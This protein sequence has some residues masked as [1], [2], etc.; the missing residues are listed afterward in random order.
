[1]AKKDFD[2]MVTKPY[3]T[4][5]EVPVG[6]DTLDKA[7]KDNLE[8]LPDLQKYIR[9]L[10]DSEKTKLKESIETHGC[11]DSIKIWN[12]EGSKY[13]II[14][15]HNR[16]DI[17]KEIGVDFNYEILDFDSIEDV[18]EYMISY[19]MGRR[20]LTKQEVSYYRGEHYLL[21]KSR[22]GGDN[23]NTAN[24]LEELSEKYNISSKSIQRDAYCTQVLHKVSEQLREEYLSGNT[25]IAQKRLLEAYKIIDSI[26]NMDD[27]LLGI[28][29]PKEIVKT[30]KSHK[31]FSFG[32]YKGKLDSNID[33][34]AKNI[35]KEETHSLIDYLNEK[36]NQLKEN[37]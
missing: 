36:I 34:V 17:C 1:M 18:K 10:N 20:N 19:Q 22:L 26:P 14:D 15:G 11:L 6:K 33:K 7:I 29:I 2:N 25:E 9:K 28:E 5:H 4:K 32:E 3:F 12:P 13:Y 16:Y 21:S 31:Q 23:R 27:F 24:I 35:S 30:E 8:V 37:L